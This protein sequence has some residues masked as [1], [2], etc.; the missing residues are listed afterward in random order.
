MASCSTKPLALP[1]PDSCFERCRVQTCKLSQFYAGHP[2]DD[3][4]I[5]EELNCTEVNGA[6]AR[7]CAKLK[8]LCAQGLKKR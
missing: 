6:Q 5:A 4:R 7:D 8:G 3:D 2:D 1:I